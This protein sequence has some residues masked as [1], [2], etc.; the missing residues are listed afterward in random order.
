MNVKGVMIGTAI[1]AAAVLGTTGGASAASYCSG[2]GGGGAQTDDLTLT[3]GATTHQAI[4]CYGVDSTQP[5][6]PTTETA[7]INDIWSPLESDPDFIYGA[8]WDVDDGESEQS[9]MGS[10]VFDFGMDE[11][12]LILSWSGD[13]PATVQLAFL[14]KSGSANSNDGGGFV[15]YLFAPLMLTD[16]PD[17]GTITFDNPI[18]HD[19]SHMLVAWRGAEQVDVPA[20]AALPLLGFGLIAAAGFIRARRARG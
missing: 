7:A 18:D 6:N 9:G 5:S 1:A 14:A 15:S 19:L 8:K 10:V 20:P 4:D 16:D 11:G 17:W 2:G 3:I 12:D 13:L